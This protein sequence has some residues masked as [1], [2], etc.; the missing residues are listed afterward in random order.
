MVAHSSDMGS[1]WSDPVPVSSE[2]NDST[3]ARVVAASANAQGVLAVAWMVGRPAVP[4]HELW[5]TASLDGGESFLTPKA[6]SVPDCASAAWST[7]GDYFGIVSS[8]SGRFHLLWGEPGEVGGIL[9]HA[10]VDVRPPT[11]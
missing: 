7:S 9:V 3:V 4:C 6:V 8:P 11:R 5:F 1:H 2:A 10:T